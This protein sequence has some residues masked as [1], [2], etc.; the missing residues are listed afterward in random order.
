MTLDWRQLKVRHRIILWHHLQDISRT[1]KSWPHC[2]LFRLGSF[3]FPQ[4]TTS[5][6]GTRGQRGW[7]DNN[8]NQEQAGTSTRTGRQK[9]L[10]DNNEN[11]DHSV[12]TSP[13][14]RA[15]GKNERPHMMRQRRRGRNKRITLKPHNVNSLRPRAPPPL[16]LDVLALGHPMKWP[17]PRLM[18]VLTWFPFTNFLIFIQ[19][20]LQ[21][22][23]S[24]WIK[25]W[26]NKNFSST[27]KFPRKGM[28]TCSTSRLGDQGITWIMASSPSMA[29]GRASPCMKTSMIFAFRTSLHVWSILQKGWHINILILTYCLTWNPSGG[30]YLQNADP[31]HLDERFPAQKLERGHEDYG[32]VVHYGH[33]DN[34]ALQG[35]LVT[36]SAKFCL[37][38]WAY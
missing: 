35:T 17:S 30:Q 3:R 28:Q 29:M 10:R 14:Q 25:Q 16:T 31:L 18:T 38:S 8:N 1:Q 21:V 2:F 6:T 15:R 11:G 9:R 13:Y 24:S 4:P 33:C 36:R 5:I 34:F 32:R 26:L 22:S 37:A 20:V 23:L 12:G 19:I 7:E 27:I